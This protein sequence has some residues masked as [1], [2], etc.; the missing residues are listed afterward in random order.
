LLAAVLLSGAAL[1]SAGEVV[2]SDQRLQPNGPAS[3]VD[4]RSLR[5][6]DHSGRAP[7]S[8]VRIVNVYPHDPSAFTQGLIFD[9]GFLYESTGLNGKSTLRKV[10]LKTGRVLRSIFLSGDYFGEGLTQFRDK[11]IQ[12]TWQSRIGF[13]YDKESFARLGEFRYPTEGWGITFNGRHLVMSDGSAT[14]RLLDPVSFVQTGQIE[15]HENGV[16]VRFLNE[17][18]YVKGEIFANVWQKDSIARISPSTGEVLGWVDLGVLRKELSSIQVVD[19]L[20]GIAYDDKGD[21]IFVTG[22]LWPKLFE[23]SIVPGE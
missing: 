3:H 17:L 16:P 11:L 7:G 4:N 6:K 8:T 1:L 9:D 19:V 23:I 15:V 18:E 13:V 14:L 12:L 20:N 21:R 22:K 5:T 10:E 2:G